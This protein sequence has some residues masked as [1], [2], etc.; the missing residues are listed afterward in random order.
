MRQRR[1]PII[2]YIPTYK[3]FPIL[4]GS[5]TFLWPG[6]SVCLDVCHNLLKGREVTL[7]YTYL[8]NCLSKACPTSRLGK[9]SVTSVRSFSLTTTQPARWLYSVSGGLYT[10][11][12]QN[13]CTISWR[14]VAKS[15]ATKRLKVVIFYY[16]TSLSLRWVVWG[17][18]FDFWKTV[19]LI[20]NPSIALNIFHANF[21]SKYII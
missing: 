4:T 14:S 1:S 21:V 15:T 5:V 6:L 16:F 17:E 18:C 10:G 7:T 8:S 11:V 9:T 19:L 3:D 20:R 13:C 12:S 2:S